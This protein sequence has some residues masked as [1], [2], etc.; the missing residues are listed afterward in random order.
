MSFAR[1]GGGAIV[2]AVA[3]LHF[4]APAAAASETTAEAKKRADGSKVVCRKQAETGS[5]AKRTKVCRTRAQ[6]EA[7]SRAAR[8]SIDETRNSGSQSGN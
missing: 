1:W 6:W 7:I 4:A 8:N 2:L 3:S 5:F